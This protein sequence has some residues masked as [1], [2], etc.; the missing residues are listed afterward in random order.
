MLPALTDVIAET[1]ETMAVAADELA[2]LHEKLAAARRENDDLR[3][4]LTT[5]TNELEVV[6]E[7]QK[8]AAGDVLQNIDLAAVLDHAERAGILE[9]HEKSAA[10]AHIRSKP[11]AGLATL[12]STMAP[13]L[14]SKQAAAAG[15]PFKA[16]KAGVEPTKREAWC[17]ANR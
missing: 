15:T 1:A 10:E 4:Q 12:I 17:P 11:A 8:Q 3:A 16:P 5:R 13:L 6:K 7:Q 9:L 2:S 14:S